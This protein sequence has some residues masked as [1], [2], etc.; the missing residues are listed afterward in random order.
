MLNV[1]RKRL[2]F[3]LTI[4]ST[5]CPTPPFLYLRSQKKMKDNTISKIFND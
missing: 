1:L 4:Q 5:L 3:T 2:N